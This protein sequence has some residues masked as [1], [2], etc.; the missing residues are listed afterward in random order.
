MM[1][2]RKALFLATTFP[3]LVKNSIFLLDFYQ[4]ISKFSQNFPWI[5]GFRRLGENP[6]FMGGLLTVFEKYAKIMYFSNFHKNFFENFRKFSGARAAPPPVPHAGRPAKVFPLTKILATPLNWDRKIALLLIT[7]CLYDKYGKRCKAL[8]IYTYVY[9]KCHKKIWMCLTQ[10]I[11]ICSP[12]WDFIARLF[13]LITLLPSSL[14]Y[15]QCDGDK[16]IN[17]KAWSSSN[18]AS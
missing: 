11:Q 18:F 16:V 1:V 14:M 9:V 10:A 3:N 17:L 5:W 13:I 2:F 6:K 7:A 15:I 8:N 12:L 4:K